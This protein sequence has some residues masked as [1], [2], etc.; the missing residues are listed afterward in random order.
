VAGFSSHQW[1]AIT[2]LS[3]F[4]APVDMVAEAAIHELRADAIAVL[5]QPVG[6]D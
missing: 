5:V 4:S 6:A 1:A 2:I 3:V